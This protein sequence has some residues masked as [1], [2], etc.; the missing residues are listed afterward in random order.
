MRFQ[1]GSLGSMPL[2]RQEA[3]LFSAPLLR[4]RDNRLLANLSRETLAQLEPSLKDLQVEQGTILLEPG[5]PIDRVYFPQ[6]GMVSLL[7]VTRDGGMIE[8]STVGREGAV[9]L[10]RGLGERRSFTRATMQV[11]G[12]LSVIAAHT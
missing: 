3:R 12:R 5:E 6:S 4:P 10:H 9:G 7:V 8:A 1:S 2:E 11:P